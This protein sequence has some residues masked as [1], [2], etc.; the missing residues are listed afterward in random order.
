MLLLHYSKALG[1]KNFNHF[2]YCFGEDGPIRSLL[3]EIGVTVVLGPRV[4]SIKNP[5]RFTWSLILLLKNLS[6]FIRKNNIHSL[7]SH[8]GQSD[9]LAVV[10]GRL[11]GVPAFPTLH[12]TEFTVDRRS[13]LDPRVY[14][15]KTVDQVIYRWATRVIAISEEVKGVVCKRYHI[16]ESKVIVVKNGIVI[17]ALPESSSRKRKVLPHDITLELFAV[18]RLT[19]QKNFEVLIR[20]AG[21]LLKR[22]CENIHV[23]IAGMGEEYDKLNALISE[24]CLEPYVELLGIRDDVPE[25]MQKADVLVMP[26]RHEGLSVAMIEAFAHGLP[27]IASDAPGLRDYIQHNEN[28][29]LFPIGDYRAL[30][31]CILKIAADKDMLSAL[32]KGAKASFEKNY[33][34]RTNIQPLLE[35]LGQCHEKTGNTV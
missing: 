7:H 21:D 8:N 6:S 29:L 22:G 26:S 24:L 32:S 15:I 31:E 28:G 35:L 19:Y 16:D 18:G 14:L 3:N 17:D 33:N 13:K 34:M 11:T 23:Q 1:K 2:V 4:P 20:A 25:L 5:I 30:A 27:V 10:V 9:K 12:N